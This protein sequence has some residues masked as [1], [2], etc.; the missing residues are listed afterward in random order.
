M[1]HKEVGRYWNENAEAWTQLARAGYDVYR[2]YF[3]TPAFFE[4]LPDVSGLRGLFK[5][6]RFTHTVSGWLNLLVEAGFMVEEVREPRPTD[7]T[8]RA[9]GDMQDAQIMP[10]FLHVRVRKPAERR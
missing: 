2:D 6:P 10:Y 3:N 5:V 8:V 7:E 1:D 4:M 9:C